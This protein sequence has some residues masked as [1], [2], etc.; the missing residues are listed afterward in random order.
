MS[1]E[2]LQDDGQLFQVSLLEFTVN[3]DIVLSIEQHTE[4][5]DKGVLIFLKVVETSCSSDDFHLTCI[6]L[7]NG[8]IWSSG[9]G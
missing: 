8:K 6:G 3:F 1:C 4:S 5:E 9:I 7:E 2:W